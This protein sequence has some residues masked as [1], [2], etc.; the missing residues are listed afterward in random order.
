MAIFNIQNPLLQIDTG[1]VRTYLFNKGQSPIS[2]YANL[3]EVQ[4]PGQRY[5]GVANATAANPYGAP[6]IFMLVNYISTANPTPAAAPAPVYWTDS[7]FTTV[8][9]VSTESAQGLNGIAG[10]LMLNTT[11]LPTLT[12]TLLN[13]SLCL[14]QVAGLVLGAVAPAALV[15][16]DW[17]IGAAGNFTPGRV[18]AGTAAGYR[19]F[20]TAASAVSGGLANLM[21]NC[22]IV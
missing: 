13:N 20:G 11:D 10:Y 7:T 1:K 6:A 16:G 19:T 8:S 14:I 12:A 4:V 21:L 2:V 9:G 17:V 3:G 22:D 5:V 18:A 15:A